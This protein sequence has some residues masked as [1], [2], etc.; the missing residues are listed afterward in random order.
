MDFEYLINKYQL[1]QIEKNILNYLYQNVDELKKIG[2]RKVAKDNYISTTTVYKLCKKLNFEGYSDMIYNLCYSSKE[3]LNDSSLDIYAS[4][5]KQ[6]E[7]NLEAFSSILNRS[8]NKLIMLLSVG[9]SQNIAN[10]INERFAVSGFRSISNTH[11]ELLSKEHQRDVLLVVISNS[12]ETQSLIDVI[13]KAKANNVDI[14]SFVGNSNSK[15]SKL[16]T[17]PIIIEGKNDFFSLKNP[18]NTF[19]SELMLIFE[20]FINNL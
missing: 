11:L 5:N 3:T 6:I 19:F 4:T 8:K 12:G 15:I 7:D 14:I 13:K 16:S 17:L 1:N 18:P 10:Y 9:I 2:I 20:C